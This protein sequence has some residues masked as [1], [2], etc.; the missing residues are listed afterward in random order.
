MMVVR[1]ALL[2]RKTGKQAPTHAGH[3]ARAIS[4]TCIGA[5]VKGLIFETTLREVSLKKPDLDVSAHADA[6]DAQGIGD[7]AL[8]P[9]VSEAQIRHLL[10]IQC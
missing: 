5:F 9:A 6:C 10:L 2:N 8:L 7:P 3:L 4:P 1:T